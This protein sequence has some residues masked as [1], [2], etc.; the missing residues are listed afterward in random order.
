MPSSTDIVC[1]WCDAG[2]AVIERTYRLSS[3]KWRT[4][5]CT[6]F[7][8]MRENSVF[9]L[10]T[11]CVRCGFPTD[12]LLCYFCLYELKGEHETSLDTATFFEQVIL[13][14]R[15]RPTLSN[16][17]VRQNYKQLSHPTWIDKM[18]PMDVREKH[19]GYQAPGTNH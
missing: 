15:G 12:E 4:F 17:R 2:K 14:Y 13:M 18:Y 10:S 6:N 11:E 1:S 16:Y 7:L 19:G 9:S 8:C 3:W 5:H